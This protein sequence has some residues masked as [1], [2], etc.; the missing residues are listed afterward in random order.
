MAEECPSGPLEEL[1]ALAVL[2]ERHLGVP[3]EWGHLNL[4]DKSLGSGAETTWVQIPILPLMDCVT[5]DSLCSISSFAI[6]AN[7]GATSPGCG[8]D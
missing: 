5:L 1:S 2:R 4:V 6:E 7:T 3:T 8:E